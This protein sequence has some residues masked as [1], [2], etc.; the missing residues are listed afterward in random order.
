VALL[1]FVAGCFSLGSVALVGLVKPLLVV[2][3]FWNE[4]VTDLLKKKKKLLLRFF[5]CSKSI[6]NS[7]F[8]YV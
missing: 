3:L 6:Y 1:C 5:V 8:S 7:F 4:T 2:C